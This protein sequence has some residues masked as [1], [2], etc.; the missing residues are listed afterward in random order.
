MH[1][2]GEGDY[3]LKTDLAHYLAKQ[4]V[5]FVSFLPLING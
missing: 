1:K 4:T 2:D 5:D 3:M